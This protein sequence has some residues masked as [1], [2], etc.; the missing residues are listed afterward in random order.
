MTSTLVKKETNTAGNFKE[1]K[2]IN[3]AK[4]A[5]IMAVLTDHTFNYLYTNPVINIFS[6]YSVSLFILVSGILCYSSLT[7]H[8]D[9]VLKTFIRFS[10]KIV[11]AY[12]FAVFIVQI[13][14]YRFFDL[15]TYINLILGF[16]AQGPY[17]YVLLYLQLMLISQ[18]LFN[19]IQKA[20]KNN[21]IFGEIIIGIA[22]LGFAYITTGYTNILNVYGGGG[23]LAGGTFILLF[24]IGMLLSKYNILAD[25]SIKRSAVMT[26]ISLFLLVIWGRF[27]YI[28]RLMLDSKLPFGIGKNP[29]SITL[30]ILT[31]IILFFCCGLFSLFEKLK[32]LNIIT[33]V[34]SYIGKHTLYIFLFHL[35]LLNTICLRIPI[36][37]MWLKQII[38]LGIMIG[39]SIIIEYT[40]KFLKKIII[41]EPVVVEN[42]VPQTFK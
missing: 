17:Y 22:L 38:Y 16:N 20:S 13:F 39:G 41:S 19:A 4:F 7:R 42:N 10:K 40:A 21:S 28:D 31:L 32:F 14:N 34:C 29:P 27:Y 1:I 35:F 30:L 5:A 3:C 18:I 33:S 24:Y 8:S 12:L 11:G 26:A 25:M 36:S 6:Y 9:T 37:S 2:W 23:K 15:Q